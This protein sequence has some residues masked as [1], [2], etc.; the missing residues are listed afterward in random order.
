MIVS[1]R[2]G[3]TGEREYVYTRRA[4]LSFST[5]SY[6]PIGLIFERLLLSLTWPFNATQTGPLEENG[7]VDLLTLLLDA[8]QK[9]D[10]CQS[11]RFISACVYVYIMLTR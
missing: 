8:M 5:A 10:V 4:I 9:E 11:Y 1:M 7:S 2:V 3:V 6:S